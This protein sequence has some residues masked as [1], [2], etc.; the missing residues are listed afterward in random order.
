MVI[1]PEVALQ[2]GELQF[3]RWDRGA[4]PGSS[5]MQRS[6]LQRGVRQRPVMVPRSQTRRALSQ[7]PPK[8]KVNLNYIYFSVRSSSG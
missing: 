7:L 6:R 5:A 4:P 3:T 2:W 8:V 1:A